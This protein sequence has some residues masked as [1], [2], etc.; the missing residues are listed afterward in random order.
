MMDQSLQFDGFRKRSGDIVPFSKE[1]IESA[2]L[3]AGEAVKRNG[4]ESSITPVEAVRLT[5]IILEQLNT[6]SSEYYVHTQADNT[7]TPH[8]E[9]VQDLVEIALAEEGHA[10]VVSAYKRYRKQREVARRQIRVR[11]N[12]DKSEIDVTDASLLLVESTSGNITKPWNR[13][14]I[15]RQIVEETDLS[16]EA[17]I[18]V[19]KE[20]ENMVLKGSFKLLNTA[21]IRELVN[22]VMIDRGYTA[23]LQ[24][25]S[26]YRI[27]KKFVEQLMFT[28]GTENSNI[29]NNNP[30][31]V[32]LGLSELVLKQW[33]LE[34]IF[35]P[36]VKRAHDT[37][38]IHLHDLGYPHRV[39]CSS[40]S[41]EYIKKYGLTGLS[42]LNTESKPARTASVLTGHLNTFLASMQANYAG[43]LGIAYINILYAPYLEGMESSQMKQIA[44]EL[45]F[46]GAQNAFSRGGQ[47]LFLDFNIHTGVPGYLQD[48]PAIGP[49]GNYMIFID[50]E[51]L[52]LEE[53]LRDDLDHADNKLMDL[54]YTDTDGNRHLVLREL[55]D[56]DKGIVYDKTV[57][58]GID[59]N[60]WKIVTY[61]DYTKE[62]RDFAGALLTVWGEGDKN[63]HIFEFPK[64]DFHVSDETFND[65]AQYAIYMKAC[66]LASKNGSTYFIFDRDEVTL[67][68]CC[69][70]RTTIQD[71]RMLKH[72]ESM[73]FCGFQNVTI[74]IPQAAYR[75][76]RKGEKNL[77]GLFSELDTTMELAVEAHLQKKARI[78]EMMSEPGRP[79]YQLGKEACDGRPYVELD[80]ATYILG[81][82]GVNDAV[83]FLSGMELHENDEAMNM[84]LKIVAHMFLKSKKLAAKHN[85]KFSLE[86]SPAE[87]AARRLAKTDLIY[88]SKE[89]T[90][91]V[92]GEDEDSIYYT[93]SIHMT[94]DAPISLVERIRLQ[95]KYH[96]MIE[97]G[98]ITHAFVGEEQP[99]AESIAALMKEVLFRTQSA[100]VTISPE[101]TFCMDCNHNFRGL[102]ETCERCGSAN[103][104]GE[105][106]VVGYFSRI[107]NWNKSKRYGELVARQRGNYAVET[108]EQSEELIRFA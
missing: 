94:A 72:P 82:I 41:I 69:R 8:I 100:Q 87:S 107:Q 18:S 45:I 65:P 54:F 24:D 47:T 6:P 43:A 53:V 9:D 97:S 93:N 4:G 88:Y 52:P 58:A 21:L 91:I 106:R 85:L 38:A 80:K 70:L 108:A 2:I 62:A 89:A 44:Q 32:N 7:R 96:S 17:S 27:P 46:N 66:E 34:T 31:A 26:I 104:F 64:C 101:F 40:H 50:G 59:E 92:K 35:S 5:E 30:E 28:K 71:N 81:L 36:E 75:A 79:L 95:S 74:N 98:A 10:S 83:N 48:V 84:G 67:S 77:T 25:L 61:G 76:A 99:S 37:G 1:K 39:Y 68:A 90:D 78:K 86:E 15:V 102:S 103:V 12:L 20:V 19:A 55:T 14:E 73:R 56:T 105:T 51:K 57:E 22:N 13:T 42:N 29:V 16:V 3:N 23:Q 63:G 60:D 49:R 11:S 33:G